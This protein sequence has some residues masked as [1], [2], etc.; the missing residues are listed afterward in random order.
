[1][2]L[3]IPG[4]LSVYVAYMEGEPASVAWTYFPMGHFAELFAGSTVPKHREKGLYT[5]LLSTRLD[6]IRERG[7]QFAV[8]E[9]VAMG[10]PILLKHGFKHLT[11]V[12]D[13]EWKGN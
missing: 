7:V 10:K 2:H 5:S 8:V 13:Y 12:W 3:Q 9:T 11:T 4:Y 1:M 6:E